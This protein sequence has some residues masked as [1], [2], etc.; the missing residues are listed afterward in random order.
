MKRK[1]AEVNQLEATAQSERR[2]DQQCTSIPHL[3]VITESIDLNEWKSSLFTQVSK[4]VADT[5]LSNVFRPSLFGASSFSENDKMNT[6]KMLHQKLG[7][8]NLSRRPGPRGTRLT[9]IESCKAIELAN[10]TFGF[11]G[12]S[13]RLLEC[14]EEYRE[15]KQDKWSIA[16]SSL[17]RIELKDGTSHEDVG[18]GQAD[19]QRDLGAALEQAKKASISDARKRAL[20][21]FG[22]YLGNSCYDKEG[23]TSDDQPRFNAANTPAVPTRTRLGSSTTIH[24]PSRPLDQYGRQKHSTTPPL[25]PNREKGIQ[26]HEYVRAQQAQHCEKPIQDSNKTEPTVYDMNDISLS[27]FDYNPADHGNGQ[28]CST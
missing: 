16:F 18:F 21:L 9:Y 27:Q 11:N 7:K 2:I 23:V 26:G 17:V 13:C 14:K 8:E 24:Q 22:E 15:K 10:Q 1:L 19:G 5:I 6:D 25:H 4:H 20:R 12:W 3:N 28:I